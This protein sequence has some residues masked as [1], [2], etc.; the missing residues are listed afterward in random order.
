MNKTFSLLLFLCL[1]YIIQCLNLKDFDYL[2]FSIK[3]IEKYS[4]RI[5]GIKGKTNKT[6]CYAKVDIKVN[7][8]LFKYDKSEILSSETCFHP[9]KIEILENITI[10]TNNTY[11]QN[12]LILAFCLY[13]T[14][15]EQNNSK[16]QAIQ[17]FNILSL[18][19]DVVKHSEIFLDFPD[20]NEFLIA[21][22]AFSINESEIIQ[23]VIE[24]ILNIRD[25]INEKFILY[26]KIYYYI[27]THSF[28]INEQAI[29]LPF[30]D[31]CNIVPYYLTKPNLNYKNSSI[32]EEEGNKIVVKS[33]RIFKQNEQYLFSYNI[34]L[35]N[36]LLMLK[37]GIFI[38]DNIHDKYIINKKFS[39]MHSY[40]SDELYNNLKKHNL[41]P[42]LLD[43]K[44]LNLGHD[45]WFKFELLGDKIS[46]L[47][48]SFGIIYFHWW[49]THSHEK[50]YQFR[51]IAKQAET[52]I[53]RMCY[54]ELKGIRKRMEVNYDE[55]LLKTQEYNNL[56]EIN[57]K[58]RNFNIEKIH[59]IHKNINY[60]YNDLALLNYNEIKQKKSI[61]VMIDPNKDA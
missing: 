18:P 28:N 50:N 14:F 40:E 4:K 52:L 59:L 22:T 34:S 17:K 6:K 27:T 10:F 57:R 35:D 25:K 13:Y 54:D 3:A 1:L 31:I 44:K 33:A 26:S 39:Y 9:K 48:Y 43:Y 42:S 30:I 23:N 37:Q 21:G 5:S 58:L 11:E 60:L 41:E 20:L 49:K 38:H 55:Y 51:H 7:D 53:L 15:L 2:N 29:I 47:L 46:K 8:T 16:I 56:T 45:I 19:I 61:Y 24:K 32:I 36:D 12:K